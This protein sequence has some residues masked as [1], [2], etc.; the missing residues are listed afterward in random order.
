MI[1][2]MLYCMDEYGD[3]IMQDL[4]KKI[5]SHINMNQTEFAELLNVTFATVNRWENGR[6]LPNKLAQD[7]IYDLC[8]EYD[9]PVYDMVLEKI[10]EASPYTTWFWRR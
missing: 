1:G 3:D 8:K 10:E 7:K 9:V 2:I 6:A 5:R 4:I